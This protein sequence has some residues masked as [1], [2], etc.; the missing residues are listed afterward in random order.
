MNNQE[1]IIPFD[2]ASIKMGFKICPILIGIL[3][4]LLYLSA[5]LRTIL[6][7]YITFFIESILVLLIIIMIMT[8]IHT[9]ILSK[10][11]EP[12]ARL[13]EK[14]I[15]IKYFGFVPWH[16]IDELSEYRVPGTPL[17]TI[18]IYVHN[19]KKIS[20]QASFNGKLKV[21]WSKIFGYP[22]IIIADMTMD[23]D[24]VISFA[25]RFMTK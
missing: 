13:N 14:G 18:A 21:F 6:G 2:K 22:A 9:F 1:L 19:L 8:L 5:G 20:K 4:V 16:E 17:A 25:H 3:G 12:Q 15:W 24:Q 10:S 7:H 11:N 23:N